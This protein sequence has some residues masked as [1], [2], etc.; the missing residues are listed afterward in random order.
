LKKAKKDLPPFGWSIFK[1]DAKNAFARCLSIFYI[2]F[3]NVDFLR[4]INQ[5]DFL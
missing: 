4:V 5:L 3:K 1:A 2:I